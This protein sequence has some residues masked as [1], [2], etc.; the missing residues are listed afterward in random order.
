MIQIYH[1]EKEPNGAQ[2]PKIH[3]LINYNIIII[4]IFFLSLL[5]MV[6]FGS[7]R[8]PTICTKLITKGSQLADG[9]YGSDLNFGILMTNGYHKMT[10]NDTL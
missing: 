3:H 6:I 4:I 10:Q 9:F 2:L 1:N 8:S 5:M 7:T